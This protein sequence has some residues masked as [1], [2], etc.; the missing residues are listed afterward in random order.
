[1]FL[2][3]YVAEIQHRIAGCRTHKPVAR[4]TP[5][6]VVLSL[7][8]TLMFWATFEY[9]RQFPLVRAISGSAVPTFA[10]VTVV[11]IVLFIV[12]R[13]WTSVLQT[14]DNVFRKGIPGFRTR[15]IAIWLIYFLASL[16]VVVISE[17]G[18]Q[19]LDFIVY[20]LMQAL[21]A[22]LIYEVWAHPLEPANVRT[23][24]QFQYHQE[25]WWKL[26][27]IIFTGLA[28]L[29]AALALTSNQISLVDYWGFFIPTLGLA[30]I[31]YFVLLKRTLHRL[32]IDD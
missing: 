16:S 23:T 15:S 21:L 32:P 12:T 29:V 30:S 5:F 4:T 17:P 18:R 1:M 26:A 27:Q 24:D 19:S 7:Y 3:S 20:S 2:K 6:A 28:I 11:S 10:G 14:Y 22:G 8:V 9:P 31:L 25:N 13:A